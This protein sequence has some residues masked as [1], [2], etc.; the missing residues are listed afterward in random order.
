MKE[1]SATAIVVTVTR[2]MLPFMQ[3]FALYVLAHGHYSPGGGFQAGAILAASAILA[4][5]VLGRSASQR[6]FPERMALLLA[7]VGVSVYTL[8]GVIPMAW[9]GNFLDY[10][11]LPLGLAGPARRAE[12]IF[13]VE[14]GVM[15][16]V[17]GVFVSLYDALR[18]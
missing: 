11:R 14:T 7:V 15:L 1:P 10:G 6:V 2:V 17:A 3:L 9:G 4:R 12:G 8:T 16:T 18:K 13:W 5:T